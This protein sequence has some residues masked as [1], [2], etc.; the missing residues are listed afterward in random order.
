MNCKI[1]NKELKGKQTKFCSNKCKG[2]DVNSRHKDYSCQRIRGKERKLLILTK[3]GNKCQKC[4][5]NKNYSAL[6]FHHL[7]PSQKIFNI[8]IRQC[9]N[10]SL[11]VLFQEAEK[12]IILCANC[13]SEY[14][15]PELY[16]DFAA[17]TN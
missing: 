2:K 5:Y 16:L 10:R 13:H 6:H 8:D 17:L 4:G 11:E 3:L 14:H 9:S 1:C 12:C 15:N 7:N